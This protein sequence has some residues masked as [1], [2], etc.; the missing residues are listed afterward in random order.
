MQAFTMT[1]HYDRL[2]VAP[3]ASLAEIKAA[4]HAKLKEFPAHSYPQEFKEIRTA[5]EA[6]RK[7][8]ATQAADFFTPRPLEATLDT[9]L[10]QQLR[11]SVRSQLEVSLEELLRETF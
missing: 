2:G 3:T 4:Y 6:I 1:S 8:E 10:L 5:Y 7:G 9:E 11:N